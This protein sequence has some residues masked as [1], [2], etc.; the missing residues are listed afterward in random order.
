VADVGVAM[1]AG[2]RFAIG[3]FGEHVVHHALVAMQTSGLR[4]AA[5]ARLDLDGVVKVLEG[6]GQRMVKAV[7]AFDN[8]FFNWVMRQVA[9]VAAGD[10]V[11]AGMLPRIEMVL[12]DV[13][14]DA[15]LG[16]AAEIAGAFAVAE[17]KGADAAQDAKHDCEGDG[18]SSDRTCSGW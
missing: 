1:Y 9:V 12:H 17:G 16:I 11:M 13:A 4:D 18:Q 5:I 14:V 15:R 6:E 10:A 2:R 3:I 7:V 8:P